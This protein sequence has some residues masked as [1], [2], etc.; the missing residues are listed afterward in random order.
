M[1]ERY[2][3]SFA[4]DEQARLVRQGRFLAPWVQPG[5]DFAGC[6]E[7]LEVG[8]GVGAQLA[9]LLERFPHTRFTGIDLSPVQL[10]QA[11]ALLA[12]P[13][14][15][16]RVELEEGSAYRLPFADGQFDGAC[17]FWVLEHLPDPAGVL[18][19][20]LRVLK[21]GGVLYCTEVFNAGLYAYP[22]QPALTAWWRMF[23]ELQRDLGGDPDVGVRLGALL[24][25]AG[26]THI[27]FREVSPQ[28]DARLRD[29][30]RRREELDFWLTLL[31]SGA[32][33]LQAH[34]RVGEGD[35]AALENAFANLT[36][37]PHSIFRYAAFQAS[38]RKPLQA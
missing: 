35:L 13:L 9:V 28:V 14:A 5:V 27:G 38:G 20:V 15:A 19:E 36:R 1:S 23:N 25:E 6:G 16:G 30:A 12:E 24:D 31:R 8:C 29:P 21:P 7:V 22:P 32:T 18:K 26:F 11:R 10:A 37:N 3:H 2:I 4:P 17:I 34:G 33:T